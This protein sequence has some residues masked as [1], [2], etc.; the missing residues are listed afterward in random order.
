LKFSLGALFFIALAATPSQAAP[1]CSGASSLPSLITG[2][3]QAQMSFGASQGQVIGDAPNEGTPIFRSSSDFETSQILRL[4]GAYRFLDRF[5]GGLGIP[6]IRRSRNIGGNSPSAS[7]IGDVTLDI[8]YEALPEWSY[9]P[10]IPHG[11]IFLQSTLP[12]SPSVLDS[13]DP[14]LL[15]ARGRGFF[16]LALGGA[17]LKVFGNFDFAL[18]AEWH[19]SFARAMDIGDGT[20]AEVIPGYGGSA[21]LGAGVS[22]WSGPV[23]FGMSLSPIFE[24]GIQT[25][26]QAPTSSASQL[27]WNTSFSLGYAILKDYS[28]SLIY[29]DQTLM[30]PAKN[31]SLSRTVAVSVLKR[32]AL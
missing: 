27:V 16:S 5:Q 19:R 23:R 22:P 29:T 6:F 24:Q 4:D 30:G 26:G 9:S 13:S 2:D 28:A 3:D 12:T 7:G 18:S 11:F 20:T 10:W 21:L 25:E 32:W 17:L 8:A 31:V 14:Y 15:D 1:C